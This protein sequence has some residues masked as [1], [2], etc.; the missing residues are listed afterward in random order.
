MLKK[1]L[2]HGPGTAFWPMQ[3]QDFSRVFV[4]YVLQVFCSW[5]IFIGCLAIVQNI[6]SG[7]T[8]AFYRILYIRLDTKLGAR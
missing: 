5:F 8:I 3:N 2:K 1:Y 6:L 7:L 4:L